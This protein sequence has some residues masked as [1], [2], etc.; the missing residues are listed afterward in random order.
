MKLTTTAI[1]ATTALAL[2]LLAGCSSGE[3]PAADADPGEVT[4]E[5]TMWVYP[6]IPDEAV[7]KAFW[8]DE[9][10]TFQEE[11][12]NVDVN[13]EVYPWAGRDEALATA[14]AGGK[15]PDVVYL[16]P[17]QLATYRT[18]IE[19]ISEY[20][21]DEHKADILENVMTSVTVDGEMLGSPILTSS[22]TLMCN[23]TAFDAIGAT[24]YPETWDDLLALA[25]EFK[26]QDIYVTQYWGSPEATLNMTFYP[27]LW[28]AGGDVFSEDNTEIAFNG[29]E[30]VKALEFLTE[31]AEN[32][33][34]EKDL[35]ST[36]PSIEQTALAKNR[37][38]CTWQSVPGDVTDFWGEENIVI[39]PPLTD[40]DTAS[41]GT[42]GSLSML[43]GAE[44]KAAAGAWIDFATSADAVTEFVTTGKYFS[45]LVST[46]ELY[47]DDPIYSAVEQT[48]QYV[49]VGPLTEASRNVMGV[50]APEI[51]AAL[52]GQKTPQ[53]ALDDAAASAQGLLS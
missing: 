45:P 10:K 12:P 35:V 38:A 17:D 21:T 34:I 23:K 33:Y 8:A 28:Q 40:V 41:Y 30:G 44:D 50:L 53:E 36:M 18:S 43:K 14:I 37:V 3:T 29:P 2:V 13:V 46:G 47:A 15:G 16:I 24:E 11:Y 6:V 7:H 27:L 5:I 25:P 22:N 26:E 52:L 49:R 1:A 42:V 20:L 51:Q 31:L 19:P 39:Q 4:G 48:I 32:D 9:V